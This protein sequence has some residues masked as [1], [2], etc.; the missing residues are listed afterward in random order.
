MSALGE[1]PIRK[2]RA[3][4]RSAWSAIRRAEVRQREPVP[5]RPVHPV[6]VGYNG[7]LSARNAIAYAAGMAKRQGRPLLVVY[8]IS[9]GIYSSPLAGH[10]M[11]L[12]ENIKSLERWLL[13]ELDEL[14]DRTGLEVYVRTRLGHPA[15]EL[16][17]VATELSADALVIGAS[18]RFWHRTRGSVPGWLARHARCPVIIVP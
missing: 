2:R 3:V 11:G 13:G 15:W 7:S 12:Q 1:E 8:A 16:A 10:V 14:T 9:P 5:P 6:I 4:D 18:A 17:A